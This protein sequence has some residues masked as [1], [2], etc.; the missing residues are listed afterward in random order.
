MLNIVIFGPPGAGKG[1]Q[2][3]NLVEKYSLIHLSTGDLLRAEIAAGSPLGLE[4]KKLMDQGHLVPDEVVVGMIDNKISANPNSKGFIF[5]GFPRTTAQAESLDKMLLLKGHSII[6]TL[7]LEVDQ[8]ELTHRILERGKASNRSDDQNES[9]IRNRISEY[10]NKTAPLKTYYQHQGKLVSLNG[11][12]EIQAIF[13]SLCKAI[14]SKTNHG[15][16]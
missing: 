12:G 16:Q 14:D 6:V 8:E 15:G 9:I 1:T 10:T 11:I 13:D 3:A 7:A 4:A 5:D 2:S